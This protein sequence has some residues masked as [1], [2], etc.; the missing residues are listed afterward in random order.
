MVS[1]T[2]LQGDQAQLTTRLSGV[3]RV[4]ECFIDFDNKACS[5]IAFQIEAAQRLLQQD[6]SCQQ[7]LIIGV[8]QGSKFTDF[9]DPKSAMLFGDGAGAL[10]I[11][12]KTDDDATPRGIYHIIT[13]SIEDTEGLLFVRGGKLIMPNGQPILR[14][15]VR[16]MTTVIPTLLERGNLQFGDVSR[17]IVHQANLKLP[18]QIQ[19]KFLGDV[20]PSGARVPSNIRHLGN[21]GAASPYL[22]AAECFKADLIKPGDIV[23]LGAVG[24]GMHYGGVLLVW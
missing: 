5:S 2:H 21:T 9:T 13:G 16:S 12:R 7:V 20:E 1:T 4:Q 11:K 18:F 6:E 10:V 22:L 8:D 19:S 17:I 14:H 3:F 15:A 23:V 24:M